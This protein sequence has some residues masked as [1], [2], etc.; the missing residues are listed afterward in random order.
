PCF[1]DID[2]DGD[3]DAFVGEANGNII[4]FENNGSV[5]SPSFAAPVTNPF[6]LSDVGDYSIPEFVDIDD[7][8]DLDA[9]IGEDFGDTYYFE[10]I[11]Y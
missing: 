10:N 9:F 5:D 1:V 4:Y 11:L 6:S 2:D 7:D 3:L 8:G